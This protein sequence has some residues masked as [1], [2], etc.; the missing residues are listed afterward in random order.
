LKD[1]IARDRRAGLR[2]ICVIGTAGTINT[3]AVDDM[4]ALAE[5]CREEDLWFHVDGAFGAL[6]RLS[7]TVQETL[8]G[9]ELADSLA[10]DLHKWMYLPFEIACALVRDGEKHRETF[11]M[12]ASYLAETTRGVIAGGLPFAERAVELTRSFKALKVWMSLKAHGVDAFARCIDQ[13]VRQA[14]HLAAL[15]EAREEL[16]LLAPVALNIVCFRYA[17]R[18]FAEP[19]LDRINRELIL[20]IQESGFAVPS[21]TML[22]PKF[23]L[24]VAI[25]NHRSR[26]EDFDEFVRFAIARG[27]EVAAELASSPPL[28]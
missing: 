20:R 4:R 24:R 11:A 27:R 1:A 16:E 14:R 10:F 28:A 23:A 22:G 12:N 5:V 15:I 13:N 9:M 26:F 3:G 8:A 18:G 17:P 7:P 25:T 19:A 6:A 21:S 2:P